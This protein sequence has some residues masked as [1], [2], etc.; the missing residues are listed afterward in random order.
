MTIKAI[1]TRYKGYRFRSRLEAR[2]A[3]FFDALKIEWE[4]EKEGFD[5]GGI[6]RYLPDFWLSRLGVWAEVKG[7]TPN[8][9]DEEKM[10]ALVSSL[11]QPLVLLQNLPLR[12]GDRGAFAF[13]LSPTFGWGASQLAFCQRC[14]APVFLFAR[15]SAQEVLVPGRCDGCDLVFEPPQMTL[16]NDTSRI[17]AAFQSAR[18]AR[19]EHGESGGK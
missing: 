12:P 3:V 13:G 9:D 1:E 5:L 8:N 14:E 19:F 16:G 7:E 15:L 10:V 18:S 17:A 4:Y 11:S 2:W 6:G